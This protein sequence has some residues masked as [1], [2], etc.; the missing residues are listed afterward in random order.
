MHIPLSISASARTREAASTTNSRQATVLMVLE[1]LLRRGR[2]S[3]AQRERECVFALFDE[4]GLR[5]VRR[6]VEWA[7]KSCCVPSALMIIP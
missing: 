7:V 3:E 6:G 5:G 2:E 1:F 4:G